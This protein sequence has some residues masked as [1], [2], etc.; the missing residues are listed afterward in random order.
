MEPTT[1]T[2][3]EIP[4]ILLGFRFGLRSYRA[5]NSAKKN[6]AEFVLIEELTS[7]NI[8][9]TYMLNLPHSRSMIRSTKKSTF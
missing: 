6:G 2:P 3:A 5:M 7:H 4:T 8:S 1:R 9:R